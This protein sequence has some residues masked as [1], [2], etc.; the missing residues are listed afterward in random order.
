MKTNRLSL[1]ALLAALLFPVFPLNAGTPD[2]NSAKSK[3]LNAKKEILVKL[4]ETED[5]KRNQSI[6]GVTPETQEML[7]DR[8]DSIC[9]AL[10][11]QLLSI[12]LE[13][14]EI[15]ADSVA[16]ANAIAAEVEEKTNNDEHKDK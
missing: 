1:I 11:S 5:A 15:A 9:L 14:E 16:I 6:S 8:Q 7:N 12:K 2:E 3:E 4:I 10:R 13:L